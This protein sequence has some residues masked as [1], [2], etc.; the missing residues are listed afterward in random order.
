MR[1]HHASRVTLLERVGLCA[2]R[3]KVT[4]LISALVVMIVA[5]VLGSGAVDRLSSGG[6]SDPGA[7]SS[8][9]SLVLAERFA[10]SEPNYLLLVSAPAG[11]SVDEPEAARQGEDL[12][13]RL[14]THDGVSQVASYWSSGRPEALRSTDGSAA[15]VLARLAGDED[16]SKEI[17][18]ELTAELAGTNGL[19]E[20]RPGGSAEVYR[21]VGETAEQDLIRAEILVFPLTF[22]LLVVI[23]GTLVAAFLPLAVGV[24]AVLGTLLVLAL[25]TEVTDVSIFAL[26]LTTALGLG[27]SI[28]YSLFMVARYREELTR[29]AT[30]EQA[31]VATVNSAG[32]TVI[33]S[34]LTVALSLGALLLFPL[35]FLRS[36]SYAGIPVVLIA[37]GAAVVVLPAGLALL[38][39]RLDSLR[40]RALTRGRHSERTGTAW[41]RLA[42]LST[43]RPVSAATGAVVVLLVLGAPFLGINLGLTDDRNLPPSSGPAAVHEEIRSGFGARENDPVTIVS[44][45]VAGAGELGPYAARLSAL[46]GVA[47]VDTTLG[48]YQDGRL[49]AP[50]GP[51]A[52]ALEGEGTHLSLV[53][54]VEAM[55]PAGEELVHHVRS[56]EAPVDV[57]VGGTSAR[58]VDTKDAITDRLPLALGLIAVSVGALLFAFSG[59]ILVPLKALAVGVLSLSATFGVLVWGFQS[60]ALQGIAGDFTVT[61]TIDLATPMLLFCVA[62]GLSMDYEVFLLSRIREEW[63]RTGDNTHAVITGIERTAGI[64]TAAAAVMVVVFLSFATSGITSLKMLGIGLAV[65]IVVDVTLVRGVLVPAVMR[66]AGPANWWAPAPLR[67]AYARFGLREAPV[68]APRQTKLAAAALARSSAPASSPRWASASA[69]AGERPTSN[70]S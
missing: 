20:V 62:F 2:V 14:A 58:L 49:V 7:E 1:V 56:S 53:P 12:A 40:V 35:Y 10:G 46:D 52:T 41:G 4:V 45:E 16:G 32:R 9:A 21:Q 61:G 25:L 44:T 57:M 37:A 3:R 70:P 68:P 59:G 24:I 31:V 42:R 11:H 55:S 60:G 50:P 48:S 30:V 5:G 38:G 39:G 54:T 15:L 34:A 66:L 36:F 64:V 65:A 17:A 8:R 22:L 43:R 51:A 29:G 13:A 23:L 27:L 6:F 19:L 47:R 33:F 63:D 67:R 18:G 69:S 28:D 26:N